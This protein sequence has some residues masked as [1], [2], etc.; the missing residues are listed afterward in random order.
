[1]QGPE[2]AALSERLEGARRQIR[3]RADAYRRERAKSRRVIQVAGDLKVS[4]AQIF[5]DGTF[6]GPVIN[7]LRTNTISE[8]FN[9]KGV[10][11][12]ATAN[13]N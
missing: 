7:E 3:V 1:V 11:E 8:S 13:E 4:S 5:H 2:R 12:P 10:R 9:A 6:Y